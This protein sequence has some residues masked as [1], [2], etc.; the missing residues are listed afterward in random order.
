M[1]LG[2][3]WFCL[4]RQVHISDTHYRRVGYLNKVI[5]TARD[6]GASVVGQHK[7]RDATPTTIVICDM[8]SKELLTDVPCLLAV[9]LKLTSILVSCGS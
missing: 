6:L 2:C 1:K 5:L 9:M 8:I 4:T 3:H 7:H